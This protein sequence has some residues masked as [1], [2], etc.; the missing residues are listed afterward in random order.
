MDALEIEHDESVVFE[1]GGKHLMLMRP[2]G[3]TETVT[4]NFYSDDVYRELEEAA[5]YAIN[6]QVKV[7]VAGPDRKKRPA[8][9]KR[10]A[11]ILRNADYRGFVVLEFEEKG[12]PR[13]ESRKYLDR[14]REAFA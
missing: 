7:S 4:L 2:I 8:D 13:E 1:S 12:D 11:T 6:V 9:F 5:P 10:I 14:L 3:D